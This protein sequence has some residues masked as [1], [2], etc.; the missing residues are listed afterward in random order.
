MA[1]NVLQKHWNGTSWEE[2]HPITKASNVVSGNGQSVEA[3]LGAATSAATPN[4]LAARDGSGRLKAA[5]P[6]AADDVARKAEVDAAKELANDYTDVKVASIPPPPVTSVNSK[7]GA[8]TL[9][10]A[11][12][13]LSGIQNYGIASQAQAEAGTAS[14]VYM[15]PQRTKQAIDINSE[16]IRSSGN[17]SLRAE[18][19]SSPPSSPVDGDIWYDSMNKK[20]FGYANGGWV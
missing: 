13:G 8:V 1:K 10:K 15:T 7:T 14:N 2:I 6:A 17:L 12:V 19:K 9:T 16:S 20:F 5:A 11:D 4:T 18:V 3:Q